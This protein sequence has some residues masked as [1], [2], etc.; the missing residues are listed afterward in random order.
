MR[1]LALV[2][3][4]PGVVTLLIAAGLLLV[5]SFGSGALTAATVQ[6]PEATAKSV[7]G[8]WGGVVLSGGQPGSN[9]ALFATSGEPGKCSQTVT[10][11]GYLYKSA[12]TAGRF[13]AYRYR[14]YV[15]EGAGFVEWTPAASKEFP[16]ANVAQIIGSKEAITAHTFELCGDRLIEGALRVD[17]E[18]KT[19]SRVGSVF[20]S[21]SSWN[22]L[23]YDGASLQSGAG[24]IQIPRQKYS[25]VVEEGET[26]GFDV[27]TGLGSWTVTMFDGAGNQRCGWQKFSPRTFSLLTMLQPL[28]ATAYD[29]EAKPSTTV[30]RDASTTAFFT[31]PDTVDAP[32][33]AASGECALTWV[34]RTNVEVTFTVPTGAYVKGGNNV[35]RVVLDNTL[36]RQSEERIV[37][38]DAKEKIPEVPVVAVDDAEPEPGQRVTYTLRARSNPQTGLPIDH[39]L[40]FLWYGSHD[41]VPAAESDRWLA[42]SVTVPAVKSDGDYYTATYTVTVD[43][44]E[45][46]QARFMSC[47]TEQRCSGSSLNREDKETLEDIGLEDANDDGRVKLETEGAPDS[48][49]QPPPQDE[50][51]S[52]AIAILAAG[53]IAGLAVAFM[54]ARLPVPIRIGLAVLIVGVSAYIALGGIA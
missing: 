23:G 32:A 8:W 44:Q 18:V 53:A 12:P 39:F 7:D 38:V 10:A 2:A 16:A 24:S 40:L 1:L 47:D 17:L 37:T 31:A 13:D 4:R 15:D 27:S 51:E 9:G 48:G 3:Q 11:I 43:R 52:G 26:I 29:E 20:R 33:P 30:D 49:P 21:S 46:V 25:D 6:V 28:W 41:I 19:A 45:D 42:N 5:A 14:V 34:G 22:T 50:R 36:T 54:A 35:W